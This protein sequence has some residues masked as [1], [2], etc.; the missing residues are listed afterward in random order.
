MSAPAPKSESIW[1]STP[2][3][4]AD[5]EAVPPPR[6]SVVLATSGEPAPVAD[7][8]HMMRPRSRSPPPP[9]RYDRP[10]MPDRPLDSYGDRRPPPGRAPSPYDDRGARSCQAKDGRKSSKSI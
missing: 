6:Q 3:A 5:E 1:E 7:M 2:D 4:K 9:A 10:R 8:S